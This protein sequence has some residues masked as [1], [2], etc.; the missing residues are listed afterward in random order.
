VNLVGKEYHIFNQPHTKEEY[1]RKLAAYDLTDYATVQGLKIQVAELALKYP[2][3]YVIT[4][5][6]ENSDGDY[7][8]NCKNSH[9]AFSVNNSEDTNYVYD[10]DDDC[11]TCMD[12]SCGAEGK[13]MYE[14]TSVSGYRLLFNRFVGRAENIFYC[15][16][17]LNG[18]DCFACTGLHS[19]EQYCVF[20]KQYTKEQYEELV[21]R[22]IEHMTQNGEW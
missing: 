1:E 2:H 4:T 7:L 18:R 17:C 3:K 16:G 12:I 6:C 5:N 14:G 10:I 9:N 15:D 22:I 21:P 11:K 8:S 20:N 13:L 19:N